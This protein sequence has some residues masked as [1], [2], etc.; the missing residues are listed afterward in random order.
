MKRVGIISLILVFIDQIVKYLIISNIKLYS[1][2]KI[3]P[4]FFYITNVRNTGAAWSIL[5]GNRFL[6]IGI[7]II[8]II[9]IYIFFIKGKKLSWYDIICYSFLFGGII[10]NLIDRIFLGYVIDYLEFIFGKYHYPVFN[11]A[12]MFI[13]VSIVLII[14]KTIWE[15]VC[16]KKELK[17]EISD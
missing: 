12:D 8:A 1:H 4:S 7:G 14:M 15:D 10:G 2:I 11:C 5:S 9:L 3:I 6:L 13:V 17:K 16:K